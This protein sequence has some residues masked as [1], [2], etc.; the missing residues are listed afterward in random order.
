MCTNCTLLALPK[1]LGEIK[2]NEI[3]WLINKNKDEEHINMI[4]LLV[5][6]FIVGFWTTATT[7]SPSFINSGSHFVKLL[8]MITLANATHVF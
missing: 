7:I 2:V 6:E 5:S 3:T 1:L 8:L 4:I